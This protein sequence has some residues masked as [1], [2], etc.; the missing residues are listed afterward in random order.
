MLKFEL[1][2]K[3]LFCAAENG[4]TEL[5]RC[6]REK[7]LRFSNHFAVHTLHS[8]YKGMEAEDASNIETL[9]QIA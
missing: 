6:T 3:I 7:I 1:C 4:I 8:M 9:S 2:E 5:K